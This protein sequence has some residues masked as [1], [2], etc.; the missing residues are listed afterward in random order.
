M[1]LRA[2]SSPLRLATR[3]FGSRGDAYLSL[4]SALAIFGA[5][6]IIAV[7]VASHMDKTWIMPS[8]GIGLSRHY[9]AWAI[10]VSDPLLLVAV[11]Y[12]HYRFR[13]ALSNLPLSSV[14]NAHQRQRRL[15]LPYL[16]WVRGN[17]YGAFVYALCVMLGI[18]CWVNNIHQVLAPTPFY[19]HDVFDS[20]SHIWGFVAYRICLFTSW[21][22]VYPVVGYLLISMSISTWFILDACRQQGLLR[23]HV[24][25]PDNCYGLQNLGVLNISLLW[26][27]LLSYTVMF[28][29]LITH[30]N[31]YTSILIPVVAVTLLFLAMSFLVIQPSY[32]LLRDAKTR[33]YEELVRW[34]TE[35]RDRK[36]ADI[37]EFA[38]ERLCFTTAYA[39]PYTKGA[40]IV[41]VAMRLL[42]ICAIVFK[43]IEQ[44][45]ALVP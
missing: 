35:V 45:Y 17:R 19:H 25:H 3:T 32:S 29:L 42:P 36:N 43:L 4:I 31:W 15:I 40:K 26:P 30:D 21:V 44:Y 7:L 12:A 33:A 9:G 5:V 11:G 20:S 14:T 24:T 23:P 2:L 13:L 34:S 1:R 41:L 27:Y 18:L 38:I 22:I 39:S 16:G 6:Q 8:P 10:L 28:L 37:S